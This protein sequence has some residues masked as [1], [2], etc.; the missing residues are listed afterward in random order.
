FSNSGTVNIQAGRL[1]FGNGSSSGTFNVSAG[2]TMQL[3][4]CFAHIFGPTS[5]I[6]GAGALEVAP[7]NASVVSGTFS[8]PTLIAAG[9]INFDS[10]GANTAT[11][12][13]VITLTSTGNIGGSRIITVT[14]RLDWLSGVWS[15]SGRTD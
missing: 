3:C 13:S 6:T 7:G 8:L 15:G 11:S 5:V 2:A 14:N 12:M 9:A 1:Q 10:V 4:N